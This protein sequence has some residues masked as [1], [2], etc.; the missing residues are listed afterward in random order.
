MKHRAD[1][2]AEQS[3]LERVEVEYMSMPG[4]KTSIAGIK[5][6]EELPENAMRFIEKLQELIGVKS[7]FVCLFVFAFFKLLI[8]SNSPVDRQRSRQDRHH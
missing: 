2:T 1:F 8:I 3:E 6:A 7:T 4:W 5:S